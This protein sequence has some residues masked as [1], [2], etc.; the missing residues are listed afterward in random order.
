MD[1][2]GSV[3][4][5]KLYEGQYSG[6]NNDRISNLPEGVIHHILSFLP[7]KYAVS[8]C[9]LSSR[10][11]YLWTSV[12]RLDFCDR[13]LH[14]E[15]TD[16]YHM[17]FANFVERVLLHHDRSCIQKFR[18]S[19]SNVLDASRV[20]AWI[21]SIARHKV[22][23]FVLDF[24]VDQPLVFPRNLFTC[25]A[26]KVLKVDKTFIS[27]PAS[28]CISSLKVLSLGYV[29]ISCSQATQNISFNFPVLE[30]FLIEE[31]KWVMIKTFEIFADTLRILKIFDYSDCVIKVHAKGLISLNL[32]SSLSCEL[33]L[34]NPSSLA[35]A[36]LDIGSNEPGHHARKLLKAIYG[37]KDL[38]LTDNSIM[39][40]LRFV[41]LKHLKVFLN[42]DWC[43]GDHLTEL[44]CHLPNIESL[45][46]INAHLFLF[47]EHG[48]TLGRSPQC[49]VSNLKSVTVQ[50]FLGNENDLSLIKVLLNNVNALEKMIIIFVPAPWIDPKTKTELTNQVQTFPRRSSSCVFE[51]SQSNY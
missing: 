23:K 32:S 27:V 21:S 28:I 11:Q 6:S 10:W 40:L 37:V 51:F 4:K 50:E 36:A 41:N 43:T 42:T 22:Q 2:L 26:L 44:L 8:T 29:T 3:K 49:F 7:T 25:E 20:N 47:G 17:M 48:W 19:S 46:Y 33:F 15:M 38:M 30:E 24:R 1:G 12:S 18:L 31:C 9:S 5:R 14:T 16:E 39:Y 45:A 35:D 34:R 13:L